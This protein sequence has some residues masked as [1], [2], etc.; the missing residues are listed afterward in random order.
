M[1]KMNKERILISKCEK[2]SQGNHD[3]F[4]ILLELVKSGRADLVEALCQALHV[5]C[6]IITPE[7][8]I[9]K[10]KECG[11][12]E[13]FLARCN[14]MFN[15]RTL[16]REW[17]EYEYEQTLKE[18]NCGERKDHPDGTTFEDGKEINY[19]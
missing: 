14:K 10:Y 8:I 5:N 17:R 16:K 18:Y 11:G 12:K 1:T 6:R 13:G 7:Q 3:C 9:T 15:K 19:D 2:A 4:L